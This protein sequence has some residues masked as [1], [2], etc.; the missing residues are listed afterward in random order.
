[1]QSEFASHCSVAIARSC[2]TGSIVTGFS[3]RGVG[4]VVAAHGN[5]TACSP[6]TAAI[7]CDCIS[8]SIVTSLPPPLSWCG[9]HH[10][11]QPDNLQR[12]QS[13][14]C[15][16][17]CQ[18]LHCRKTP[19]L[20]TRY[21]RRRTKKAYISQPYIAAI[22][23]SCIN[24]DIV[25]SFPATALV[26]PSPHS[27]GD[28]LQSLHH[29]HYTCSRSHRRMRRLCMPPR[30]RCCRCRCWYRRRWCCRTALLLQG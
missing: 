15:M 5:F 13:C 9:Y 24:S 8:G 26:W 6:C 12:L 11:E 1:M 3:C 28:N 7:A 18:R 27:A 20:L 16:W 2:I 30:L 29:C 21:G 25:T 14:R 10:M 19:L 4:V 23:G 17:L 22:T